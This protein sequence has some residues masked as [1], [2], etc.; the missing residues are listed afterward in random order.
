VRLLQYFNNELNTKK[1]YQ[2]YT[3]LLFTWHYN[4][5]YLAWLCR[6]VSTGIGRRNLRSAANWNVFVPSS[7]STTFVP[8]R[9]IV[10][11]LVH[12]CGILQS[13]SPI[14]RNTTIVIN[15]PVSS[16]PNYF[17]DRQY[18]FRDCFNRKKPSLLSRSDLLLFHLLLFYWLRLQLCNVDVYKLALSVLFIKA[19]WCD[20]LS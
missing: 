11:R 3:C 18:G 8:H 17:A 13:P 16:T 1:K 6:S 2:L 20:A 9:P 14:I 5:L 12:Q 19:W 15:C 4:S 7:R 10:L